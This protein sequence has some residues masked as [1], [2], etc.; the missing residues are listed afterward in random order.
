MT[1]K[2]YK[3]ATTPWVHIDEDGVDLT[4][5]L[6][7]WSVNHR[8]KEATEMLRGSGQRSVVMF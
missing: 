3:V 8:L 7:E 2:P 5:M 4:D 6:L 1:V